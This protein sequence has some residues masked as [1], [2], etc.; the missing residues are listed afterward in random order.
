M[1][2]VSYVT[3][4]VVGVKARSIQTKS[5]RRSPFTSIFESNS[6]S[7]S[8]AAKKVSDISLPRLTASCPTNNPVFP[9]PHFQTQ[10]ESQRLISTPWPRPRI[11]KTMNPTSS[12]RVMAR[13]LRRSCP[14]HTRIVRKSGSAAL[15]TAS[16]SNSA[17]DSPIATSYN[18]SSNPSPAASSYYGVAGSSQRRSFHGSARSFYATKDAQDKDSLKPRATEY[19]KS[20]SDDAAAH[21][22]AAFDPNQTKPE[23]EQKNMGES[24]NPTVS[25]HP[26]DI[27]RCLWCVCVL[28]FFCRKEIHYQSALAILQ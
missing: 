4:M 10:A 28:M 16:A 15:P 20:G 25:R 27:E 13:T 11:K 14:S 22:D 12:S 8:Y 3:V 21:D 7:R 6:N 18:G 2:I 26:I 23:T 9:A 17:Y 5:Q 19:S 24:D 1:C